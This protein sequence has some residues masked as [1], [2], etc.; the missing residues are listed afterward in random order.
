MH[1]GAVQTLALTC[2]RVTHTA[3]THTRARARARRRTQTHAHTHA[4]AH[5]RTCT[6]TH[7]HARTRTQTHARAHV[8]LCEAARLKHGRHQDDVCCCVDEVAE[9][10]VVRKHKAGVLCVGVCAHT[11]RVVRG[12]FSPRCDAGALR[13]VTGHRTQR[14]RSIQPCGDCTHTH[15][16]IHTRMRLI[17]RAR[18]RVHARAQARTCV[19]PLRSSLASSLNSS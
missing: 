3:H 5:A 19:C 7:A 8:H 13:R 18:A 14:G 10:L 17:T 6:H 9:R 15:T 11:H 2:W 4:H 16:H 12:A 1:R